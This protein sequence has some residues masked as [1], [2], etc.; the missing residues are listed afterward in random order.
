MSLEN[1]KSP[2][3]EIKNNQGMKDPRG[4]SKT[5]ASKKD[6]RGNKKNYV[7][8][9]LDE[10][11]GKEFSSA[12]FIG[13]TA[14][15]TLNV[16]K[17]DAT[18]FLSEKDPVPEFSIQTELT[19]RLA[20]IEKVLDGQK[21]NSAKFRD[22]NDRPALSEK[23]LEGLNGHITGLL[24]R[25]ETPLGTKITNYWFP[26]GGSDKPYIGIKLPNKKEKKYYIGN[27]YLNSYKK[28]VITGAYGLSKD[29]YKGLTGTWCRA[30]GIH[31][32]KC[33]E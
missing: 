1:E 22:I 18:R 15:T 32:E 25:V 30:I 3:T 20:T 29:K 7:T 5:T 23:E 19:T 4:P 33:G 24:K 26:K 2:N 8:K 14:I 10:V 31:T 27:A 16:N 13:R 9:T 12:S 6:L 17:G 28:S 11:I 21:T